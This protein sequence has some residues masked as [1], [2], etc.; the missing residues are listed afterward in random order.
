MRK[1]IAFILSVTIAIALFPTISALFEIPQPG[2][3]IVD[4][5]CVP[6]YYPLGTFSLGPNQTVSFN[7]PATAC[8]PLR[9]GELWQFRPIF[10]SQITEI[11]VNGFPI[12]DTGHYLYNCYY[13]GPCST[14]EDIETPTNGNGGVCLQFIR[15]LRICASNTCISVQAYNNEGLQIPIQSIIDFEDED[16]ITTTLF[17]EIVR[18][19]ITNNCEGTVEGEAS[20]FECCCYDCY[21]QK[22][23]PTSILY[24]KV[25]IE[26]FS[27]PG[28]AAVIKDG[29]VISAFQ[30]SP[31]SQQ[32]FLQVENRGFFTQNDTRIRFDGLPEGVTVEVIPETQKIKAHNLGTY[33]A[34]FT[35]GS[36]V[37]SGTY[38]VTMVTYSPKGMF[39]KA[40]FEFVVP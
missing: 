23:I 20:I 34:I 22:N 14:C 5:Y 29:K 8:P 11:S 28:G 32:V 17:P 3:P 35:V 33:S 27:I 39:D 37:P 21:K 25:D 26:T 6:D 40:T 10:T 13:K 1:I 36:N 18:I 38:Q 4:N 12:M 2:A 24:P 30:M 15:S 7:I 31:G 16:C 19:I 9:K